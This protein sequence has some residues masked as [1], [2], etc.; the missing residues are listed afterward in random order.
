ML[1]FSFQMVNGCMA[2]RPN[3]LNDIETEM[4][5]VDPGRLASSIES[6][7]VKFSACGIELGR[8]CCKI[9]DT[10]NR[11]WITWHLPALNEALRVTSMH[12]FEHVTGKFTLSSF[13]ELHT[14]Y[15]RPES[16]LLE[17]VTF[18]YWLLK[19]HRCVTRLHLG[20]AALLFCCFSALLC[21][22]LQQNKGLEQVRFR[23]DDVR[24][25]WRETRAMNALCSTLGKLS[26][27]LDVLDI[28]ALAPTEVS[29]G[30]IAK[31]WLEKDAIGTLLTSLKSNTTLEELTFTY[32]YDEPNLI[33]WEGFEALRAN[34]SLKSIKLV[35]VG[36]INS[37]ALIMAD[38]LR[39][40]NVLE[41]VSLS[42]NSISDLGASALAKALQLNSTLK[43]LD[44]SKCMPTY[45]A[46]S[47]FVHAL[48]F[49]N[50]VEC[51]RL[52]WAKSIR[53]GQHFPRVCVGWTPDTK[54]S[55]TVEWFD[56]MRGGEV[57]ITELI[58]NCPG[59]VAQDCGEAVASFLENTCTLKKLTVDL[60]DR[61]YIFVAAVIRSLARNKSVTEARF[62]D[63][64][65]IDH[66]SKALQDL[67][68]TNRTLNLLAFK[69]LYLKERA[70]RS[71][72]RALEDNFVLLTFE[73]EYTPDVSMYLI[74]R[75]LDRNQSLLCRAVERV[76]GSSAEEE[77]I[78]A[79]RLLSTTD[80]LL[81]AVVAASGKQREECRRHVE[82][83][84]RRL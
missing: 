84:V 29:L 55:A 64:Y 34:R 7:H 18:V 74:Y 37:C 63:Y 75:V 43:R 22:V 54:S 4:P 41:E 38:I 77:S 39:D 80:S 70:V 72:A 71:L 57:W 6:I 60:D 27:I 24:G 8:P 32:S 33:L 23:P 73:L 9:T 82:E 31:A 42:D 10:A 12:I 21:K 79:L 3:F 13:P 68:R 52:D 62:Q 25:V 56:A 58:I 11:C 48:S 59:G 1:A 5:C 47:S 35:G 16:N 46:L 17:S 30:G 53:H 2:S 67:M 14:E 36:L 26:P 69:T 78:R 76:L 28:N 51:V 81:D 44:I 45:D 66:L 40:N 50:T 15:D 49:N 19:E 65:I 20:D 83:S 61:S